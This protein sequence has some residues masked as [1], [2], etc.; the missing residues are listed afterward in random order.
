MIS[1]VDPNRVRNH[2][3]LADEIL[4]DEVGLCA[5]K[6]GEPVDAADQWPDLF[7]FD[8][9]D[10]PAEIRARA[11]ARAM[12]EASRFGLILGDYRSW[13]DREAVWVS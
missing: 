5:V 9:A 11:L 3:Q 12:V 10:D 13:A 6:I 7:R 2:H 8:V 4:G 1:A